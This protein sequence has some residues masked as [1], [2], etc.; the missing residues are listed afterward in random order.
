MGFTDLAAHVDWYPHND[1]WDGNA[2][3]KGD[4]HR[5]SEQHAHLPQYLAGLRPWFLP[6]ECT[7]WGTE[8]DKADTS[9]EISYCKTTKDLVQTFPADLVI[10]YSN[11]L[12][13]CKN[14]LNSCQNERYFILRLQINALIIICYNQQSIIMYAWCRINHFWYA[15][16]II[17]LLSF[18]EV[19]SF[20]TYNLFKYSF[21]I[22][23]HLC[24]RNQ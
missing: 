4:D 13:M 22:F 2:C 23:N 12:L 8:R 7:S 15:F 24:L 1:D 10:P 21:I 14:K 20:T 16:L 5:C 19:Q 11:S 3:Y 17:V 9:G 18:P 6:P